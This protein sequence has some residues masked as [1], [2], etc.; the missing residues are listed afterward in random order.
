MRNIS[1]K[2]YEQINEAVF[3]SAERE[4]SITIRE[5]I[6][7]FV[8]INSGYPKKKMISVS[9]K[10]YEIRMFLS[11]AEDD[12]H[13][14]IKEPMYYFLKNTKGKIIPIGVD[15]GDNYFCVNNDTG[16][17]YRWVASDNLY[18]CIS[19]NIDEFVDLF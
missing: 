1:T 8:K 18:Y 16:K 10:Q 9:G 2:L 13:Y 12:E 14:F 11:A 3:N 7:E 19:E 17:V 5:D 15:S 4:F 6:K